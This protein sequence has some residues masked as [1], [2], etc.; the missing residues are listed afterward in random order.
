MVTLIFSSRVVWPF[1]KCTQL[2]VNK[3]TIYKCNN[4]LLHEKVQK[5]NLLFIRA[6]YSLGRLIACHVNL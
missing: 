2:I 6:M 3:F 1:H 4:A 5:L